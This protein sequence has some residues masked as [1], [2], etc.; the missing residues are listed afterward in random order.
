M[1]IVHRNHIYESINGA[2]SVNSLG[3][4]IAGTPE[5]VANFWRWFAGSKT[6]DEQGRP[7]VFY[8]GSYQ[9]FEEFE[10]PWDRG[11][12]DD[13]Y[14]ES[15]IG[16]NLGVGFYF[17]KNIEYAAR[18]GKPGK[19]YLKINNL[20]DL[21][22][23]NNIEELNSRY[24]EE[25]DELTY[26]EMGEIIDDIMKEK[27]YDGVF[28]MDAGGLSYGADEWKVIS[29]DQVKAVNNSGTFSNT[30]KVAGE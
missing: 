5:G 30:K 16:G 13:N 9:E 14:V 27:K 17:T 11:E 22:D 18:F 19:Y 23:E 12:D 26:G 7:I 10:H 28:A 29:G 24:N 15:Y 21:N 3:E 20:L 4:Q 8:H 6:V 25:K 1:K 2:V